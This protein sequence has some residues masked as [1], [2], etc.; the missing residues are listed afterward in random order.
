MLFILRGLTNDLN[1][2]KYG[3]PTV[4]SLRSFVSMFN[5]FSTI[6]HIYLSGLIV[7]KKSPKQLTSTKCLSIFSSGSDICILESFLGN[8]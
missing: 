7:H 8:R 3:R 2:I 6:F 4:I 5:I 1:D